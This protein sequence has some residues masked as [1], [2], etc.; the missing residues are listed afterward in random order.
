[1]GPVLNQFAWPKLRSL[2]KICRKELRTE[3][4]YAII[5]TVFPCILLICLSL[6]LVTFFM[7]LF[8]F[9]S[10]APGDSMQD[11]SREFAALKR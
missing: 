4:F 3:L 11:T 2:G 10:T 6:H 7:F 1:M 9:Y 8:L 5:H